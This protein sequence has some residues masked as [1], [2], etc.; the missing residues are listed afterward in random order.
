MAKTYELLIDQ[1]ST[2]EVQFSLKD[3]AGLALNLTGYEVRMQIRT[4]YNATAVILNLST[5]LGTIVLEPLEGKITIKAS[6][7]VTAA[8]VPKRYVYDIETVSPTGFV[9][10][11]V[12]G[13]VVV[14]P[15]VT[16]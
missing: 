3:E 16:R 5:F 7:E 12:Q 8:L 6:A 9:T 11:I 10:R 1:G 2:L 15:E 13:N 4:S 14:S